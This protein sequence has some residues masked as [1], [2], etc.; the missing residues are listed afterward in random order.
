M[1]ERIEQFTRDQPN[2]PPRY[3]WPE[4]SDGKKW[5]ATRGVD[6]TCSVNGFRSSLYRYANRHMLDVEVRLEG[7][8]VEFQFNDLA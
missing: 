4:W 6:F 2:N 5:R 7:E 1:A 8:S 3:P